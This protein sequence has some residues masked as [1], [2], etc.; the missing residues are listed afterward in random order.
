MKKTTRLLCLALAASAFL[1]GCAK[2]QS[3]VVVI[4]SKQYLK[5][6]DNYTQI[7]TA[8]RAFQPGE[9]IIYYNV[10]ILS[11]SYRGRE[12]GWGNVDIDVPAVPEGYRLVDCM[13]IDKDINGYSSNIVYVFENEVPVEATMSYNEETHEIGYFNPGTPIHALILEKGE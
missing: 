1:T 7:E 10:D 4:D 2:N 3:E 8:K 9:H 12:N 6:G 5:S 13:T 11:K